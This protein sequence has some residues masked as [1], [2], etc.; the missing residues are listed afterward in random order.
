MEATNEVP[1]LVTTRSVGIRYGLIMAVISIAYFMVLNI[2]G[3]DMSEG[4]GRWGGIIFNIGV[5]VMAH[6]FFKDNNSNG[7][8]SYGQGFGIG[9]WISLVN[10]VIY[11]I[12][13]YI[14]VKF[15]DGA[16]VTMMMDKQRDQMIE[17]G[18]SDEQVDQAM[19]MTAKFMTPEMMFGFGLI[20]GFIIL[21]IVV[22]LVTIFTQKKNPD[23]IA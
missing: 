2:A 11:S 4:I 6:K 19:N 17:R 23:A 10:C 8:M 15:I 16:F 7:F 18:M 20:F 22:A 14:Y 3:V 13:F 5:I 9:T 12:F 21:L 1:N